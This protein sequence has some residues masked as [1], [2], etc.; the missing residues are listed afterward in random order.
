MDNEHII[1]VYEAIGA[2][3]DRMLA[4]ARSGDWE[5]LSALESECSGH[6]A[7]IGASAC[8]LPLSWDNRAR[9]V[10]LIQKILAHDRAIRD[11][12]EPWMAQLAIRINGSGAA[13][14]RAKPGA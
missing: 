9:K 11:I 4:A 8:A 2:I 5:L 10:K 12:A 3:T 13:P 14:R 7:R 6:V 1:G